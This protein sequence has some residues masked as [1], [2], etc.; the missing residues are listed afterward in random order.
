MSPGTPFSTLARALARGLRPADLL[1]ELH[2]E[3][4]AVTG[5]SRSV[6]LEST[7]PPGAF[8]AS[9]GRGFEGL[10]NVWLRD[11]E[12]QDLAQLAASGAQEIELSRFPT[13]EHRLGTRSALIVP[14]SIAKR[15]TVLIVARPELPREEALIAANPDMIFLAD[16]ECCGETPDKVKARVG[17]GGI[18]AIKTNQVYALNGDVASRWGPRVVDLARAIA[19]ALAKAPA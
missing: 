13:L 14:V 15:P 11:P 18:N 3:L 10:T 8:L 7:I 16:A 4:L 9:S 17:W 5:A 2:R 1:P 6:I 12:A 19:D